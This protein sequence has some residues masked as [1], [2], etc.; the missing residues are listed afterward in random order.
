MK[1]R[2]RFGRKKTFYLTLL[3]LPALISVFVFSYLPMPGLIIAFKKVNYIDGIFRSPWNGFENFKFFFTSSDALSA[4]KNTLIY[5]LAGIAA[6]TFFALLVAL[7]LNEV[8]RRSSIKI[9]QTIFFLP[10]FFS[11]IVVTYMVLSFMS[12]DPAG[13][14]VNLLSAV[15][16]DVSDFYWN[17]AYWPVFIVFLSVWKGLGYWAVIYYAAIIGIPAEYYEA[18]AVDGAT[19]VQSIRYIT[20]PQLTTLISIMV[21]LSVGK[22]FNSDFGLFYFVPRQIGYLIPVTQTIDTYVYRMLTSSTDLGMSAAVGLFQSV[23]AFVVIL[24]SNGI[25]KRINPENSVF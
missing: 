4:V 9:Y 12:G 24:I 14:L 21:L 17:A 16:I 10:Y 18:A 2:T 20:L 1:T 5:N 8:K 15:G 3:A 25:V 6:G 23:M 7:G 11:W 13:I 22:I 19:K